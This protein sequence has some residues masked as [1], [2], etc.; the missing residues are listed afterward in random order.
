MPRVEIEGF[1]GL[2][3]RTSPTLLADNQAQQADNVKLYSQELRYWRGSVLAY[4]PSMTGIKSIFRLHDNAGNSCWL[5]WQTDVDVVLGPLADTTDF[6]AYYTGDGQPKK[7][8][9]AMASA[10]APYPHA[11]QY[12]GVPAPAAAPTVSS[13]TGTGTPEDRVYVYTYVNVFG[14]LQEE[15]PPSPAS[16]IVTVYPGNSV[17]VNG[18]SA[19]P[20]TGYD[21]QYINIYRSVA[22]A[23]TTTYEF[24]AQIPAASSSYTDTLLTAA[25]G[26]DLPTI[27]FIPPPANMAGLCSLPCGSLAGFVGN[28]V[29]FSEPYQP[30]AWPMAYAL[31][32]PRNVVGIS[33]YGNNVVACTDGEPYLITGAVPGSMSIVKIPLMEPCVAK[34]SI[35]TDQYGV[36]YASPNGL[37]NISDQ[38]REVIT[39]GIMR[40]DEW[41]QIGEGA[42]PDN[43]SSVIYD[44]KYFGTFPTASQSAT[45]LVI[46]RDD[47]PAL[48]YLTLAPSAL[49]VD[50]QTAEVFFVN[51]QDNDIYQ[52][53]A[54]TGAAVV[55]EWM[56]KRFVFPQALSFSCVKLDAD[57]GEE[58]PSNTAAILSS[59]EALIAAG[60][61]GGAL[62]ASRL[63]QYVLGGDA[64]QTTGLPAFV[65]LQFF[66][67]DGLQASLA[68]D[69]FDVYRLPPFKSR[70]LEVKLSGNVNVRSI[71]FA[72]SVDE[73]MERG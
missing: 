22:G 47:R 26:A 58:I 41:Q 54:P 53:D 72:T 35:V 19:P 8:N 59:N 25:L 67:D 66:T 57:F 30:H 2:Q 43:L 20:T 34:R 31:S 16:T 68:I 6:R 13:A 55:Y 10:A 7:T 24:V 73:L 60:T 48:S 4:Q 49:F 65:Q 5:T 36:T 33:V 9:Y 11:W 69:S 14:A 28:T 50:S 52:L 45:T 51:S 15:G 37:V 27:G 46:T 42:G 17:T 56:S 62:G 3:P 44:G 38:I 40:R 71:A 29:Y 63:G 21:I 12:L 1:D 64:L 61:T 18:F 32:L 70:Q 39:K 23:S